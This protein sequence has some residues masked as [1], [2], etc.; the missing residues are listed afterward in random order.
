MSFSQIQALYQEHISLNHLEVGVGT[1]YF[2]QHCRFKGTPRIALM[3]LNQN[4]L[5]MTARTP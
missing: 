1:G 2:L 3:D 4:C 5:D